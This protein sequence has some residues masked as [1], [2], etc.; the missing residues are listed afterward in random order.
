MQAGLLD[1]RLVVLAVGILV[2][3]VLAALDID[4]RGSQSWA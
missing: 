4:L 2:L 3:G 1:S